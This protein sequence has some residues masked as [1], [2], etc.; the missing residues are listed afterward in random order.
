[1][2]NLANSSL[3]RRHKTSMFK[4]RKA[5][6]IIG[7]A[8]G[9]G[10]LSFTGCG[11]EALLSGGSGINS[12]ISINYIVNNPLTFQEHKEG[13]GAEFEYIYLTV[14]GLKDEE[15][16]QSINGRIKAVFDSLCV[17]D[18]PP[19]RGIKRSIAEGAEIIREQVYASVTG[20][21]NNILSIT[22]YKNVSYRNPSDLV[23]SENEKEY[24][25]DMRSINEEET[26]NFDLNT[27]KEITLADLFC[28]DVDYMKLINER[29][30]SYLAKNRADEEGWWYTGLYTGIK[31][32]E[33]FKG[34]SEDQAFSVS[35]YGI[36]LVFD[37]RTPQFDT[38]FLAPGAM[39]N[40]SEFGD[41]IAVTERF[42]DEEE[43][44]YASEEPPV[45]SLALKGNTNDVAG[46]KSW[47]EGGVTVYLSWRYS[48]GLPE[49]IG[50]RVEEMA[51][52][53][54]ETLDEAK[55]Y[56]NGMSEAEIN[57]T[58]EGYY[59]VSVTAGR[60]GRYINI[61]RYAGVYLPQYGGQENENHCYD[62]GTLE[63][64]ELAD[65]FTEGYDYKPVVMAAIRRTIALNDQNYNGE[66]AKD[67][68][69][70]NQIN[71]FE[72]DTDSIGLYIDNP[73]PGD[74]TYP[75]HLNIPYTDFGCDNMTIF[76]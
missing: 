41:T 18:L 40:F 35:P 58:G 14:D 12:P 22:I 10:L 7:L 72:L 46:D 30:S 45:K 57:E 74:R 13:D 71:G 42:Y 11:D 37:Y 21:F 75:L 47:R 36:T 62:S 38:E 1:M 26:L 31:L 4:K 49:E 23:Y 44:I 48:S 51:K 6:L 32:V 20:N 52:V 43:N 69:A 61:S 5:F 33:S 56:F 54:Q 17:R 3:P 24:Y 66:P 27:G 65:L 59:D 64:L 68:A 63:E 8:A 9:L 67:E 16:E 55:A 70:Y 29:M 76:R 53:N 28:D 39:F 15:I 34:L 73:E 60:Y 25:I 50:K 19:Y 2:S